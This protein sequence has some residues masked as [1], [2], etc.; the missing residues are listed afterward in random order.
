MVR[1][2]GE[3]QGARGGEWEKDLESRTKAEGS[4]IDSEKMFNWAQ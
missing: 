4:D 2:S 1:Q 3:T